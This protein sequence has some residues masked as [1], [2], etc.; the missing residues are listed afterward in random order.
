M[1]RCPAPPPSTPD[2]H[3]IE[4]T[5]KDARLALARDLDMLAHYTEQYAYGTCA[6]DVVY[7]AEAV[8]HRAQANVQRVLARAL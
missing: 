2:P 6:R 7:L 8:V 1:D 4:L 5:E 3:P